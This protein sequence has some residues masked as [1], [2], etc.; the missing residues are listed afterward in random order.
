MNIEL[1]EDIA[2]AFKASTSVSCKFRFNFISY[3]IFELKC[4]RALEQTCSRWAQSGVGPKQK[5]KSKSRMRSPDKNRL[6][7]N[8]KSL[9][10]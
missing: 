2:A 10:T 1:D 3:S 4:P 8:Y 6:K 5:S 9:P 7:Q